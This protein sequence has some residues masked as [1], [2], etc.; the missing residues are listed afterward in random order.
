MH[1]SRYSLIGDYPNG[2]GILDFSKPGEKR[3]TCIELIDSILG[4]PSPDVIEGKFHEGSISGPITLTWIEKNIQMTSY[5][6][7]GELSGSFRAYHKIKNEWM[8]GRL[9]Q[10]KIVKSNERNCWIIEKK[11]VMIFYIAV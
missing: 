9:T 6:Q 3:D 2:Y 5:T 11:V 4:L 10:N 7:N 1:S 8:I